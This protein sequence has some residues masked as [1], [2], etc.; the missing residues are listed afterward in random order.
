MARVYIAKRVKHQKGRV[1]RLKRG[2]SA[3]NRFNVSDQ[4]TLS[5]NHLRHEI[6]ERSY[7]RQLKRRV[8]LAKRSFKISY[9]RAFN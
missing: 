5:T 4:P 3:V 2:V 8:F 1:I 7:E 6:S 9:S